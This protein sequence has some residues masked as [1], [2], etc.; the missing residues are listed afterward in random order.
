MEEA[1]KAELARKAKEEKAK[2]EAIEAEQ[3]AAAEKIAKAL[4]KAK[5]AEVTKK[6]LPKGDYP[7]FNNGRLLDMGLSQEDAD[8][9]VLE[10]IEQIDDH[11]PQL[12]A[13]IEAG[14]H[15]EIERLT[16]S[17]KG[18]ATNLGTGGVADAINDFNTYCK[19]GTDK[20]II[21][22]HLNNLKVYQGKLKSQF[23]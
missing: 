6:E 1:K 21:L 19:N 12:E 9:F 4:E 16:H 20:E 2:K 15:E 8:S 11:L 18:S 3:K 23:S 14:D 13:A 17:V 22:A 7:D 10:L 5:K